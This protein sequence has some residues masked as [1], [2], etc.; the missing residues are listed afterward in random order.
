MQRKTGEDLLGRL[1]ANRLTRSAKSEHPTIQPDPPAEGASITQPRR[2]PGMDWQKDLESKV[3]ET[4]VTTRVQG[5]VLEAVVHD[6]V[7]RREQLFAVHKRVKILEESSGI[8]GKELIAQ[9]RLLLGNLEQRATKWDEDQKKRENLAY[10]FR[11][12][13]GIG[14][15]ALVLGSMALGAFATGF[16]FWHWVG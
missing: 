13:I 11:L 1:T 7:A 6:N 15:S 4:R 12:L 16:V 5:E 10:R 3:R 14:A 9:C 8:E 2:T